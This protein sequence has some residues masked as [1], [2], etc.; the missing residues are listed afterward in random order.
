MSYIH[1]FI[2]GGDVLKGEYIDKLLKIGKVYNTYGPTETTVCAAYY[3]CPAPGPDWHD[4]FLESHQS[5]LSPD[6]P[7][8]KPISNYKLYILDKNRQPMPIGIT[9]ELFISGPGVARG[10]LNNPELTAEKFDHDLWDL[11]DYQ[12]EKQK[13]PFGQI[14]NACGEKKLTA[15]TR[16]GTRRER[17]TTE[18]R[19]QTTEIIITVPHDVAPSTGT[20]ENQHR[21][22]CAAYRSPMPWGRR[23]RLKPV[24]RTQIPLTINN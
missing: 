3:H 19:R 10:Y 15:K 11:W 21:R 22:T 12:D 8:G 24:R 14:I 23:R 9:G 6:I 17:Q 5:M 18:D 16:E 2:S 4:P 1:T 20:N 7:I 13:K